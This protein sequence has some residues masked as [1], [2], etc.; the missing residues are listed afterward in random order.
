[1]RLR[2]QHP[3]AAHPLPGLEGGHIHRQVG[4]EQHLPGIQSPGLRPTET[5]AGVDLA[6]LCQPRG[7]HLG[8]EGQSCLHAAQPAPLL[9]LVK[10]DGPDA[11]A[12]RRRPLPGLLPVQCRLSAY[13]HDAEDVRTGVGHDGLQGLLLAEGPVRRDLPA[14]DHIPIKF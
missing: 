5:D 10:E 2:V 7:L 4:P 13:R 3:L 1:M 6:L 14:V 11:S 8:G 9:R 12:H